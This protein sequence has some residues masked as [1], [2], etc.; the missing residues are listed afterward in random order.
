VDIQNTLQSRDP[1]RITADARLM[2]ERLGAHGGGFIAGFYGDNVSIGL[3]P[4]VQDLACRAFLQYGAPEV[5]R[6]LKDSLPPL[7]VHQP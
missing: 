1:A 3:D 2:I 5:W 7:P 4:S 6:E